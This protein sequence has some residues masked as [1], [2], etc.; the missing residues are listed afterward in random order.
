MVFEKGMDI[1]QGAKVHVTNARE[2]ERG[3][4]RENGGSLRVDGV[5]EIGNTVH[6]QVLLVERNR[7]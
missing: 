1:E 2:G 7:V 4:E 3:E 5:V 6:M